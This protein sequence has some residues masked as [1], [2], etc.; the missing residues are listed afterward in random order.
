MVCSPEA[1]IIFF[2]LVL[3]DYNPSSFV[4]ERIQL[5]ARRTPHATERAAAR[6]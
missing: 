2:T 6:D 1:W 5:A 4:L 3:L